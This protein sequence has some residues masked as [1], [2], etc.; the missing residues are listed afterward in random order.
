MAKVN[1]EKFLELFRRSELVESDRIERALADL[2]QKAGGALTEDVEELASQLVDSGLITRWQADKLLDG[3]HK[4]FFLGKY[5]LLAHLGSGGMSTV[6]LAEHVHMHRRVAI[7]VLPQSR[8]E[9]SSYLDRFY[10]EA[11]AAAALAHPNIITAFDI[12]N[13]DKIHFLVMEYVEGRDLQTMVKEQGPLDYQS[14]ADFIGQ[15]AAGLEHAHGA[16]LV[17]RDIKPANLLVD[18]K[19]TVKLLDLGLALFSDQNHPSLT[20]AHDENVLGTADY[21]APEQ[22]VNSHLVDARADI[23]S[24]GCTFYYVLTGHPPFNEGTLAQ[25]LLAHQKK[26]PV[27]IKADRSDAPQEFIDLCNAMMAKSPERRIQTAAEVR[28]RLETW[29]AAS[30]RAG[31]MAASVAGVPRPGGSSI[32][33]RSSG[34]SGNLSKA[35]PERWPLDPDVPDDEFL[36][37]EDTISDRN[38]HTTKSPGSRRPDSPMRRAVPGPGSRARASEA[39]MSMS[40][41]FVLDLKPKSSGGSAK[42]SRAAPPAAATYDPTRRRPKQVPIGLWITLG[43]GICAIVGLAVAVMMSRL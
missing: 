25:R 36:S 29:L 15:A 39:D 42:K 10:L 9:D 26:M 40:D 22:A 8:V 19:G 16:G 5:K 3:K 35:A 18:G 28:H 13:Q 7:K 4:G 17:H 33:R 2:R 34:R 14:A 43:L 37:P 32:G 31:N 21:L 38:R 20:I 23:Y 11:K 27:S 24:L 12:D 1:L 6:Y 30:R 41:S